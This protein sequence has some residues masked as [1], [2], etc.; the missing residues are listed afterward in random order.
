MHCLMFGIHDQHSIPSANSLQLSKF[1]DGG[2]ITTD[3]CNTA[4]K[5]TGLLVQEVK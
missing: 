5:I 3:I 1:A 2:L 4:R